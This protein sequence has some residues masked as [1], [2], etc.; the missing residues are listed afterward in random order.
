MTPDYVGQPKGATHIEFERG[1]FNA[2]LK[3]PN[4]KKVSFAGSKVQEAEAA[5][6]NVAQQE[7]VASTIIVDHRKNKKPKVEREKETSIR[8]ILKRC[9]DFANE[10]PQLEFVAHKYLGAFIR[11]TFKC[12]PKISG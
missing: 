9:E 4:G 5:E 6:L 12:H 7:V 10:T 1:F 2:S 8:E 11:L 3:L